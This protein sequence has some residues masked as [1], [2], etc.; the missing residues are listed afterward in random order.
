M[1]SVFQNV[2]RP[3]D[4]DLLTDEKWVSAVQIIFYFS[5]QFEYTL[6]PVYIRYC[7]FPVILSQ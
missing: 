3:V 1:M 6:A 5:R 7:N 4:H 2:I